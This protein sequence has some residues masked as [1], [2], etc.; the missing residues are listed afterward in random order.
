MNLT[1]E[2]SDL[3]RT[4]IRSFIP[5][6]IG[7]LGKLNDLNSTISQIETKNPIGNVFS[8]GNWI[9]WTEGTLVKMTIN[10]DQMELKVDEESLESNE[11]HEDDQ[12]EA[13]G[14]EMELNEGQTEP[15]MELN[16]DQ[17]R[18][19]SPN[20][21]H[22]AAI[23]DYMALNEDQMEDLE[24]NKDQVEPNEDQMKANAPNE[25]Q[26]EPNGPNDSQMKPNKGQRKLR[27]QSVPK[28]IFKK[29]LS[30]IIRLNV[31]VDHSYDDFMPCHCSDFCL[32]KVGDE[33]ICDCV[34]GWFNDDGSGN[35]I[36]L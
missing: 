13:N 31:F 36:C 11:D 35:R 5:V 29:K 9:I 19:L 7:F 20:E 22:M 12:I 10:E 24:L 34:N 1:L 18:L 27:P 14:D 26:L 16:E 3:L 8:I 33:V 28:V 4:R 32:V 23:E 30:S 15:K 6:E 21:D 17:S 25:S 2:V